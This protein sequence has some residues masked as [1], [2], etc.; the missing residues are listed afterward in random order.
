M[1]NKC[2]R[3]LVSGRVQGV[4][5]R[6]STRRQ[7]QTL[8]IN[9]HAINL[10]DGRVEVLACGQHQQIDQLVEWLH[11]GPE[12]ASVSRVEIEVLDTQSV[13]GFSTG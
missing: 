2:I 6:E 8:D 10:A 5:F 1:P 3:A 12:Y 4:F 9:G 11:V 13:N 7:A